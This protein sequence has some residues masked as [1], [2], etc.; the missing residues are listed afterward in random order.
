MVGI[1][2]EYVR[3]VNFVLVWLVCGGIIVVN[4][5]CVY[6]LYLLFVVYLKLCCLVVDGDDIVGDGGGSFVVVFVVGVL[7]VVVG[8]VVKLFF[9]VDCY[10]GG[11]Y[12]VNLV[13]ERVL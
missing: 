9:V 7:F 11:I 5:D 1:L 8:V 2:C 10:F 6:D 13:G 3:N 12:D 4:V